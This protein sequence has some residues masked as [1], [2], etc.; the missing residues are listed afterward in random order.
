MDAIS[1]GEAID[2]RNRLG[3]TER[4][5]AEAESRVNVH[6][7]KC[8]GRYRFILLLLA[9]NIVLNLPSALPHLLSVLSFLK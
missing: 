3:N 9:G 2:I 1:D 6:E 4:R 8:A 5:V 7:E